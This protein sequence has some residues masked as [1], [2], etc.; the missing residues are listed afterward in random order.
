MK[1]PKVIYG[2]W[3]VPPKRL[4]WVVFPYMLFR[5]PQSEVSDSLFRHEW[6]HADQVRRIGWLRFYST[7]LWYTITRGYR[8]NPYEIEAREVERQPLTAVQRYY[9]ELKA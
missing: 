6:Q 3:L 1:K 9:K 5:Q 7:Y 2:T 4:A 8:Y